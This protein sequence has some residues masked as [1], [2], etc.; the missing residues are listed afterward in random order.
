MTTQPRPEYPRPQFVREAWVNLNGPWTYTFDFGKSGK[1]NGFAESEGFQGEILVP[2]CPESLLSGVN[3]KDFIEMLWY[4]R[5]LTIP[6]AWAGRRILLHFG[7]VDYESEVFIDGK[8]VGRHWGGTASFSY[9]IT[10]YVQAGATHNLVVYVRDDVR[11]GQQPGGKQ[12]PDFRSRGCHYTRTTGIWQTVWMEAVAE[13]GLRDVQITPDVDGARFI[14]APRFYA[15]KAGLRFRATLKVN[16]VVISQAESVAANGISVIL[17]V[18]APK[19]WSPASPFLYDLVFEVLDGGTVVD[20]VTSYAGLRKVRIEGNRVFLNNEPI[21]LRLVLDQGFYPDG[22][23][24]APNDEALKRDI[25]LSLAAGFNGARLHQKVFEER[26]H[27]WADK[28]GYLTWGES[29]S[30]GMDVKDVVSA[31]NFLAE[32]REIVVRDR[33][34]PSIITW[35]P[36]NETRDVGDT[37]QH[38]RLHSDAAQLTR[39]LDATRP[40]ND[41]SGYVHVDTDLW[42]VH[43]YQQDPALLRKE[44]TPLP[45]HG[46]FR[47]F[48]DREAP[49]AGQP[50]L[51]DE[52][53]GIKWIPSA[54]RVYAE[55]SWGYGDAPQ[56]LEEF[57][58]RLEGLTDVILGFD[59]IVG[60]CYTQLTDVEQE[61]N[62]I[63]NYD[64]TEK[65]DM[66]RIQR[67]F[68]KTKA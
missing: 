46:P 41:A 12:C 62:G 28:L 51:V 35:T 21:Y 9:D 42:T 57:Y 52:Y 59:H 37:R 17:P 23:W 25:E 29:S 63:Y 55:N 33:N 50:Y 18:A 45:E 36:F 38:Y 39:D 40:V 67:I 2:F 15:L 34:H 53:G 68:S 27:Y 58:T 19:L 6:A 8:S 44:L 64:R 20:T 10:R 54:E 26:F 43:N 4:H 5:E 56:T 47:N 31:R 60:Y 30:W 61:Q 66:A 22:I 32:W 65:F 3:H 13:C 11:S 16:D 14:V 48:P 24:T 49:Y 7:A 1:Q